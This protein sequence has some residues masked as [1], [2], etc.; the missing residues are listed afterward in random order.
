M[1][2]V[3]LSSTIVG[4]F[5]LP[6]AKKGLERIRPELEEAVADTVVRG[7]ES[8]WDRVKGLF[9]GSEREQSRWEFFEEEPEAGAAM[10]EKSLEKKLE[11]DP[12]LA[13]ELNGLVNQPV[14][15][16]EGG[17]VL[18]DVVA[19]QIGIVDFRHGRASDNATVAG[20]IVESRKSSPI[21]PK[22]GPGTGGQTL[23]DG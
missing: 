18:K 19:H 8:V 7:M 9:S 11:A 3:T 16:A 5:L 12:E 4:T 15:A 1:D 23:P 17:T 20:M 2:I 10:V 14:P 13:T 22:G 6:Y 21:D